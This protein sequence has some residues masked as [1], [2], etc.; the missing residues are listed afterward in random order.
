MDDVSARLSATF[1]YAKQEINAVTDL[2]PIDPVSKQYKRLTGGSR[3]P[4]AF[5][6]SYLLAGSWIPGQARND[7]I[8]SIF[9]P[10][11]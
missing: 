1:C 5:E 6:T 11:Q 2:L 8:H 9:L 10:D 4:V 3:Y 7:G